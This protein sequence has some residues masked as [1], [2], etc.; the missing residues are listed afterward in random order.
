MYIYIKIS[1][2][3][4]TEELNS[5]LLRLA[6]KIP[7]DALKDFLSVFTLTIPSI[8]Q[9]TLTS[10]CSTFPQHQGFKFLALFILFPPPGMSRV[11]VLILGVT[12]SINASH[13]P[14]NFL[15]HSSPHAIASLYIHFQTPAYIAEQGHH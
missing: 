3:T 14:P 8:A 1:G 9:Y 11:L 6:N 15:R 4:P 5:E 12:P 10:K 13:I 7:H 2:L